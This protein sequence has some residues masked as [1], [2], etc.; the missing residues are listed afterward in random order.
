MGKVNLKEDECKREGKAKGR[1]WPNCWSPFSSFHLALHFAFIFLQERMQRV[2][3]QFLYR[4]CEKISIL[5]L[6]YLLEIFFQIPFPHPHVGSQKY[7][8]LTL[9]PTPMHAMI[10]RWSLGGTQLNGQE[11]ALN[12]HIADFVPSSE[13]FLRYAHSR[14]RTSMKQGARPRDR[15]FV[16]SRRSCEADFLV[17]SPLATRVT[18]AE[19]VSCDRGGGGGVVGAVGRIGCHR[20]WV[21][22]G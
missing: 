16:G 21:T 4:M 22:D 17:F 18:I 13:L 3:Y 12:T 6:K 7:R 20:V 8:S 15:A 2:S 19:S 11:A 14:R 1:T 9:Y 5:W 10:P